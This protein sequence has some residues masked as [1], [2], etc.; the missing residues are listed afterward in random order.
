MSE[1]ASQALSVE[2]LAEEFLERRRKG[3]RPSVA[4]YLERY[5]HLADEIRTF[6]PVLGLVEDYKPG[7]GDQSGSVAGASIPGMESRL[8]RLGDF[9]ILRELGR[10]GMGVVYE[11]EQESLGRRVALKVLAGHRLL[12]PKLL[13]RFHREA[14]AAARLHHT[15]IVP[16]FG[17]GEHEGVHYYVMQYI[18]GL[19]L[20]DVLAEIKHVQS[21]KSP[22][23]RSEGL[24]KAGEAKGALT[25][26]QAAQSLLT[27]SYRPGVRERDDDEETQP[28]QAPAIDASSSSV[29]LPGQSGLSGSLGSAN[30]Y[31]RSVAR[32]GVQVAEALEYAHAQGTLHRDI[33]PSN[34]LL[35]AHG[36]V[37]VTDFGLAKVAADGDLT[38]TGDIVGTIRYMAPERFEGKCDARSDIYSLGLTL[39]EMLAK[40]PAFAGR[41]QKELI[42]QV[43]HEE[44]RRLRQC[45]S[46][47]PRDLETIIHKALE[48]DATQRYSSARA[49]A[50]D[51]RRFVDDRPIQARRISSIERFWRWSKRNPVVASLIAAVLFVTVVGFFLV[52]GQMRRAIDGEALAKAKEVEANQQRDEAKQRREEAERA[53]AQLRE[54]QKVLQ[55]S[56][57]AADMREAQRAWEEDNLAQFVELLKRH[58]PRKGQTDPPGF[59]LRYWTRLSHDAVRTV[60][61]PGQVT[62]AQFSRDGTRVAVSGR[63]REGKGHSNYLYV[64]DPVTGKTFFNTHDIQSPL[65]TRPGIPFGLS[66]DGAHVILLMQER[67]EG[68]TVTSKVEV[69]DITSGKS[70][71]GPIEVLS[72]MDI[73]GFAGGVSALAISSD[74]SRFAA[75]TCCGNDHYLHIYDAKT[76]AQTAKSEETP[77]HVM[78]LVFSHDSKWLVGDQFAPF[79]RPRQRVE[80]H[81]WDAKTGKVHFDWQNTD[82]LRTVSVIMSPDSRRSAEVLI[83]SGVS[84]IKVRD[85]SSKNEILAIPGAENVS[86]T[87]MAFNNDSSRLALTVA[88]RGTAQE[89]QIWDVEAKKRLTSLPAEL[90]A[91]QSLGQRLLFSPSGR[92]LAGFGSGLAIRVWDVSAG[93]APQVF[94]AHAGGVL[95]VAFSPDGNRLY[96]IGAEGTLKVSELAAER[97]SDLNKR[98]QGNHLLAVSHDGANIAAA[99]A[100]KKSTSTVSLRDADGKERWRGPDLPGEISTL[101]FSPDDARIAALATVTNRETREDKHTLWVGDTK[102]G[103][104]LFS[105]A[106]STPVEYPPFFG[107]HPG[108]QQIALS[109]AIFEKSGAQV[110]AAVLWELESGKEIS[111]VHRA[112]GLPRQIL[113]S[114]DGTRLA[115]VVTVAVRPSGSH[116]VYV[117]NPATR[118]ELFTL[119][120][121]FSRVSFSPKGDV[122]AVASRAFGADDSGK[123]DLLMCDSTTGQVLWKAEGSYFSLAF[124]PD[125]QR[126]AVGG[127]PDPISG[128]A[129]VRVVRT[130]DGSQ[131]YSRKSHSTIVG[132]LAFNPDGTRLASNGG[133]VWLG[134][135]ELK[136]WDSAGHELLSLTRAGAVRNPA[137]SPDGNRLWYTSG[138]RGRRVNQVHV[139]DARPLPEDE[140]PAAR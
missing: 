85:V 93:G 29:S 65:E 3:E 19:G 115:A 38:H 43:T 4:E 139:L 6:F 91:G 78:N 59:E 61:L 75:A 57:Y 71:S 70:V 140:S 68:S 72:K 130:A 84:E 127:V 9:R 124:S 131:V 41:D 26:A 134:I 44:P 110:F 21:E 74:L 33:K 120:T 47:V 53:S 2:A 121:G 136:L 55:Q 36:T 128:L 81:F 90:R 46:T 125:G 112:P 35:D 11:A 104:E 64:L 5:P 25:A 106:F 24:D 117:W 79:F 76:G 122:L 62:S 13:V 80:G 111:I 48:K 105:R 40:R 114:S 82:E 135:S 101:I 109:H 34:L 107:F 17:V 69:W 20:D 86:Y 32:I 60:A 119:N 52:V 96:S 138:P 103:K 58:Q 51:L 92:W 133:F 7:S 1:S 12:D 100:V 66:R 108:G 30:R 16:V 83:R 87:G 28:P 132:A 102:T 94:K 50:E 123:P 137:F 77:V 18:Q 129:E 97:S 23:P 98:L 126:L 27:G 39:Y 73:G 54:T 49:F 67:L 15:N 42:A 99:L 116:K 8:D 63:I 14:K 89:I 22:A 95:E 113:F 45:D 88:L 118:Q 56:L 37:W 31:A 10:G